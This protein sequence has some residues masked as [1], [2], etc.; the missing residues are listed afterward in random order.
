MLLSRHARI[1]G[2]TPFTRYKGPAPL[3]F[4]MRQLPGTRL[5][6]RFLQIRALYEWRVIRSELPTTERRE[7]TRGAGTNIRATMAARYTGALASEE[8]PAEN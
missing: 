6:A 7:R 2:G 3:S 1:G 8:C 5:G 4:G